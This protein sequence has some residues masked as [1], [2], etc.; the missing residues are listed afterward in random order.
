MADRAPAFQWYPRDI[1]S[2]MRVQEMTL[3]EEGVYRRLIDY[4][5][6]NGYVPSDPRRAARIIGKG[7]T[8]E[9]AQV[10]L[11]MFTPD[12]NNPDRMYHD[13][14]LAEEQKQ[15]THRQQ[16]V[17]AAN[18]RWGKQGTPKTGI[19]NH[20]S[21]E[22]DA[23][24]MR[25]HNTR[26]CETDA[27]AMRKQCSSSSSSISLKKENKKE[28]NLEDAAERIWQAYPKK[29]GKLEGIKAILKRLHEGLSE[30]YLLARVKAYC[31]CCAGKDKGY[32]KNA[33]G[34]FNQARY[35]DASLDNPAPPPESQPLSLDEFRIAY[36]KI[37]EN[38]F[39]VDFCPDI[40]RHKK[41]LSADYQ[42]LIAKYNDAFEDVKAKYNAPFSPLK[43]FV[44]DRK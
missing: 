37:H 34:W 20:S 38:D 9:M 26:I 42:T 44:K 2:S 19:G 8:V 6:I 24:A 30:D 11:A 4:C 35:L 36:R 21:S 29:D 27:S 7:A 12:P 18:A 31:V 5:W 43:K 32:V 16:R 13:R 40:E 25:S 14:L 39:A 15:R 22:D 41:I 10:A 17:N 3:A 28:K 33:Q 23:E 1:L